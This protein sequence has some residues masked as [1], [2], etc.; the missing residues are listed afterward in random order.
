LDVRQTDFSSLADTSAGTDSL[1]GFARSAGLGLTEFSPEDL[2]G[3]N[4]SLVFALSAW[5]RLNDLDIS[6]G[7]AALFGLRRALVEVSGLD[8]SSEPIPLMAGDSR[9]GLVGLGAYMHGLIRRA[10]AQA[11]RPAQLVVEEAVTLLQ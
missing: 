8:A 2:S 6:E 1:L 9:T 5:L 3:G 4:L 11:R 10:A 7:C